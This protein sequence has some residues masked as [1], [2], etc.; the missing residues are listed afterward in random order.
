MKYCSLTF[1]DG[2]N[3]A[4]DDT[5]NKMLDILEK[6]HGAEMTCHFCHTTHKFTEDDIKALL[7]SDMN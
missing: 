1:D 6:D 3:F 5:M 4:G 7:G 2:P